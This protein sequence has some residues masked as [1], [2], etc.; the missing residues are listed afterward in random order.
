MQVK[1]RLAGANCHRQPD[2]EFL[3]K[4]DIVAV[5]MRVH[6]TLKLVVEASVA[7]AVVV[8]YIECIVLQRPVYE[9]ALF[10]RRIV[11]CECIHIRR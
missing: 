7:E 6:Y 3:F 4:N 11:E 1:V 5:C 9:L 2:C 10:L 8:E